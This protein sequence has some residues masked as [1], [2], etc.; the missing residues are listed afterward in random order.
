MKLSSTN[1]IHHHSERMD[2]GKDTVE[3]VAVDTGE[4]SAIRA[5]GELIAS[6]V[7]PISGKY[8]GPLNGYVRLLR[9]A[10]STVNWNGNNNRYAVTI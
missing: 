6:Y 9:L 4:P 3:W 8:E 1:I 10:G 5:Q 2:G 7:L